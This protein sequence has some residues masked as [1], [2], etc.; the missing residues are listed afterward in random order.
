MFKIILS[1]TKEPIPVYT[2]KELLDILSQINDPNVAH[3]D[4]IFCKNGI[5]K[6]SHF[7]A[8]IPGNPTRDN[9][10]PQ[11]PQV[12]VP[13]LE[14]VRKDPELSERYKSLIGNTKILKEPHA[15]TDGKI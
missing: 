14:A 10:D 15:N 5:F 7:S 9:I 12:F 3:D 11:D 13:L 1:T 2:G 8:T 6:K 4:I